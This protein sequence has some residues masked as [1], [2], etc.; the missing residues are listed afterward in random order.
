M[1][2]HTELQEPF[3]DRRH[4]GVELARHLDHLKGSDVVVL[5]LPR[6]GVPGARPIPVVSSPI[7][8]TR[9]Y[10]RAYPN[11]SPLSASGI[12]TSGRRRIAKFTL[13]RAAASR[14]LTGKPREAGS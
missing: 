9:S 8:P 4:A 11:I 10:V 12:A 13:L 1:T 3:R 14:E 7:S 6:G 2:R 5:A